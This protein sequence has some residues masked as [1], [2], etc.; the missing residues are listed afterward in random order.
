MVVVAN[1]GISSYFG[2][3][4]SAPPEAFL[5]E[6]QINT[7]GPITLFQAV[8]SLLHNAKGKDD[9]PPNFFAISSLFGSTSEIQNNLQVSCLP[10]GVARAALNHAMVKLHVGNPDVIVGAVTLGRTKIGFGRN[11]LRVTGLLARNTTLSFHTS[12]ESAESL[13]N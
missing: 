6:F 11:A 12:E 2:P 13:V 8:T 10:Y 1:S 3:S 9:V 4:A 7:L 5:K